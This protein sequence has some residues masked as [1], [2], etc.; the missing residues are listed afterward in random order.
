MKRKSQRPPEA[1]AVEA[2]AVP[3]A[4]AWERWL[5]RNH[6]K[7]PGVWLTIAK[8]G[9]GLR[10][11]TY[12]EALD[13]ALAWGWIDGQKRTLDET[14]WLQRFCPRRP[15][16]L[17]SQRNRD[18]VAALERAGRMRPPGAAA[19]LAAKEDGRWDAA[20][21]PPSRAT[22]PDDLARALAAAPKAAAFFASLDAANRYAVL[23]RVATA[24]RADARSARIARLVDLLER[25]ERLHPA[26]RAGRAG[27]GG[28][29]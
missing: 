13:C 9:S 22:V 7:S 4:A 5:E 21:A 12:G 19:V 10:T 25:G 18:R 28:E 20:Y 8:V 17:W 23:W 6:A 16:A 27:R 24:K 2:F 1:E 3:S 15:K 14:A 29:G 26:R 11:P